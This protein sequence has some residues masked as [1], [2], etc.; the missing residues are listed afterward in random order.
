[1]QRA[2]ALSDAERVR[3]SA[4]LAWLI[5]SRPS[6]SGLK[7]RL[8]P[9]GDRQRSAIADFLIG[10]AGADG[11]ISPDEI[12]TLGKLYPMLGLASDERV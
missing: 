8:E 6:L 10:V 11:Q 2:L 9:L 12:R 7:K 5:E 3:L 4:H 1:M